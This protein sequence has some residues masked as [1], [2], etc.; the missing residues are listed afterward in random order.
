MPAASICCAINIGWLAGSA[1][2]LA[3][4]FIGVLLGGW[5]LVIG[6][7]LLSMQSNIAQQPNN[8]S[9]ASWGG[10]MQA[11]AKTR[12]FT[13]RANCQLAGTNAIMLQA[14]LSMQPF[15]KLLPFSLLLKHPKFLDGESA[16]RDNRSDTHKDASRSCG[17]ACSQAYPKHVW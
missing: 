3:T 4:L 7:L 11:T 10:A 1:V 6:E 8:Q 14:M 15:S 13:T 2:C 12:W 17:K 9:K 16:T 5:G